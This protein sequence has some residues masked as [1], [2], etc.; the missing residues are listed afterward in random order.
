VTVEAAAHPD[1]PAVEPIAIIG[2]ACRVP[3]AADVPA[4]WRNLVGGVDSVRFST[5]EEQLALGVPAYEVDDPAYVPAAQALDDV[6]Y[7]D[8][9]FFGMT[10]REAELRDPQQRIFLELAY[11]ALA[12][13]G[14]DPARYDGDVGV[15][16]GIG[17][18]EYQW[19]YIRRNPAAFAAAGLLAVATGNHPDYQATLTSYKLNLRGPSLTVHTACSTSLVAV[20]LAS[21]ALRNSECDMAL[22]GAVALDLPQG[23]GY[24]HVE[25]GI[26]SPDGH[27]R[28][29]DASAGGTLWGNGGGVLV[30]KRLAEAQADGDHVR[31]VILGNAINNDGAAKVGFSAPSVDGQAAVVAQA[32][33]V[34]GVDPRTISYVEAHGTGTALGDP[35]EV[36]ALSTAFG[37]G[38]DERGWCAIGSVKTNVGHLGPAA[39]MAGMIK[40][41]LALEHGVIPPSLHFEKPHP[42]IDFD[43]S[44]FYV[45]AALSRWDGVGGV[46]RAGVSS[47]GIGGTNAHVLVEQAP[48]VA[49]DPERVSRPAH[50]VQ[51]SARTEAALG[52]STARLAEHL[53]AHPDL[54]P[55]DVAFTL[56]QGRG[57]FAHRA[58]VVAVDTAGAA[59]ALAN[60]K[61]TISGQAA[62]RPRVAFLFSGQGAQYAGMSGGLHAT[63]PVFA[64]ALD[65]CADLLASDP[66]GPDLRAVLFGRDHDA[67][68]ALTRT[69]AAQPSLFAVEYALARLFRSWGLEPDAMLGHSIGEYVAATLAGVFT[70]PD[71]LRLV[72][73]RGR[74]MQSMPAGSMLAV[75]LDEAEVRAGLPGELSVAAVNGPGACVI[76]GPG[77]A[78]AAY[79]AEL[80]D[81]EVGSRVLRTSHAFHSAM[82]EPILGAFLREVTAVPRSA[83]RSAFLSNLTGTWITPEQAADPAYWV[84]HLRET[85]RFGDCVG[86]LFGG[87]EPWA[88]VELGPGRQLAGLA[89]LQPRPG[90]LPP[91]PTLPGPGDRADDLTTLYTAAARLWVSGVDLD[92]DGGRR[93]GRR[94][95]LPTYPFERKYYWVQPT[96][97][98]IDDSVPPSTAR[99]GALPVDEW[100]AAPVWRQLPPE[101]PAPAP[102]RS[103]CLLFGGGPLAD[104]IGERLRASGVDVLPVRPG[105]RYAR[106]AD[107]YTV[108][109][110]ERASLDDLL[111]DLTEA[112][113]WI[114]HA[115]ALD[116]APAG[117]DP[118]AAW[119][120]QDDGFFSVLALA[121][122]L[123]AAEPGEGVRLDVVT[124]GTASVVGGDLT[125]PEH[126]TVAGAAKVLPLE[127]GWLSVRHLDVAGPADLPALVGELVREPGE[128]SAAPLALRAGRRWVQAFERVAVPAGAV[129][130]ESGVVYLITGGTGG[131]GITVAE[132][133]ATRLR[134]RL[135]L[136]ARG[137]LPDRREWDAYLAVHGD[138][139]RTGRAIAAIGRMERAGAEV[140][141]VAGDVT[142]EADLQAVR[143]A[144]LDRFG[145]LDVIVH[146]AGV[147]G[148]GMAEVKDR[149]QAEAV[150]APKLLGTL[151]LRA[152]F[153]DLPLAEVVLCSSVT[154]VAGGFG[155][156]DYCA[157]NCFMDALAWAEHGFP[158]RVVSVDWGGWLDVGMAAEVAAPD[159]FRALQRGIVST[160]LDHPLLS[161][162][163]SD[164]ST[165][166]AWCTGLVGPATHW[167]LDEHRIH[168]RAVLPG[169]AHLE[170]VRAAAATV[171]PD[172]E[173]GC[174]ELRDVAFLQP[175][176]VADDGRSELRVA[177]ADGIDQLDFQVVSRTAGA[178]QVHVR[179]G[180]ALVEPGQAPRH[181]LAAIRGRCRLRTVAAGEA[182]SHSGGMLA[183]GPHWSSLREVHVGVDEELARLELPEAYRSEQAGWVLHPALLDEATSFGTSRGDGS[184][185]PMGYG[186]LLV[187]R[188]LPARLWSHLRHRGGDEVLVADLTLID[189]DGV[190]VAAISEFV[191]RKVDP[192]S[193]RSGMDGAPAQVATAALADAPSPAAGARPSGVGIPPLDGAEAMCRLLAVDLGPQV[194]VTP[195]DVSEVIAGVRA[196][197]QDAVAAELGEGEGVAGRPA[198]ALASGSIAP[199]TDLE[200]TLC[201]LWEAV[202]GV[203]GIGVDADFFELGG[204]S[205]VAV[206]LIA[207]IRKA[208]R[209]R[210]PMRTLFESPTVAGMAVAIERLAADE[211]ADDD[212]PIPRLPRD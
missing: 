210:L 146:A 72:A 73:A 95:P 201:E 180:A 108:A 199:R 197:T 137:P 109:P 168:G 127:L 105:E 20:H 161:T 69:E 77:D 29:F 176:A 178:E 71:A 34:S 159:A 24:S 174:V 90:G 169:T 47:F 14:Y 19:R 67:E 9:A 4:F 100:F 56:R 182:G 37:Q 141:V 110:A 16:G 208:T 207:Q 82:M 75:Q 183:F 202:L 93:T 78:V 33:G 94:V 27:C 57:V 129:P 212:A 204:N 101:V 116:A 138:R 103:R 198:Q 38:T 211:P 17:S 21:E 59:A 152:A 43:S 84:R 184:Y 32:L 74:L 15:Y 31:A 121:Q 91:L 162:V 122:A 97:G 89:R 132:E 107:G 125:R 139:D 81:R 44:P 58:A 120:A 18:D 5:R 119:R 131:I 170:A 112:P 177:L 123:A 151:R 130:A 171:L 46:R 41:V 181:D 144:T 187:R 7:F 195:T 23:R 118:D 205:L 150:L 98:Q 185:L 104:Q 147:P 51:V 10:P 8:A 203:T 61:R 30:L 70:L 143:K 173:G 64:E 156:V 63:E 76:S 148:G 28:A 142:D 140:L 155:Q 26:L 190:E 80:A 145:R 194:T 102:A 54:D 1:G 172:R 164:P 193:V 157:A 50:L 192:E 163:H 12:D 40:T 128:D 165:G 25:G 154:A 11:T 196:V 188:P 134:A 60:P 35:I 126:A 62:A 96:A 52:T 88:L 115:L 36:T 136:L 158:G 106:T 92:V 160:P 86:T 124:R 65:E 149:A 114:V 49:A 2:M 42:K 3:G 191:L 13:A 55:A 111:A 153:A 113:V 166:T 45:N 206:Q 66:D 99:A 79:A 167:V 68:Q 200:R 189:D 133:L 85:V 135:V 53:A 22:A 6:E 39:G 209:R 48:P 175:M 83:P 87:G 179:G 117:A 186:R